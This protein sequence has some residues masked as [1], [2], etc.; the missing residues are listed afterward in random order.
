MKTIHG[1]KIDIEGHQDK[2]LVPFLDNAPDEMLPKKIVIERQMAD[3]DYP[4]CTAAFA[5]RG[6]WLV[7]RPK[8]NSLYRLERLPDVT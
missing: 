8:T 2:A 6:Y 7:G 3:A 4:G 1:L 5:R